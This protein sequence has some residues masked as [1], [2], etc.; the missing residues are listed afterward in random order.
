MMEKF[1]YSVQE[2]LSLRSSDLHLDRSVRKSLFKSRIWSPREDRSLDQVDNFIGLP[3][4]FV[5]SVPSSSQSPFEIESTVSTP[6]PDSLPSAIVSGATPPSPSTTPPTRSSFD[7]PSP[8]SS[9]SPS[10][11]RQDFG[12]LPGMPAS[13]PT[14]S[15]MLQSLSLRISLT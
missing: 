15:P 3:R 9:V 8:S 10:K 4:D 12:L 2:L 6:A 5:L 1:K 7:H 14:S 13:L 11:G